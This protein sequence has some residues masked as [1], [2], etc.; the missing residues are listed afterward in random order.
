MAIGV[1]GGTFDPVHIGHLRVAEEIREA[2]GLDKVLFVPACYPPHKTERNTA[3]AQ[4]RLELLG[5]AVRTAGPLAVSDMEVRRGGMSY[6]IDTIQALEGEHPDLYFILGVDA[7]RDI[8]TW[9]RYPE[10]FFHTNFLVM[11]RESGMPAKILDLVP[12]DVRAL[13]KDK[14]DGVLEHGSGK[15]VYCYHVTRLDISSTRIRELVRAGKSIRYLVP[16][17]VEHYILDK[18]LYRN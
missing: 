5:L 18:G 7:F 4:T 12:P 10:L 1:F 13:M 8:H 16:E 2:F 11:T 15:R 9:R 3:D 17:A 14:G 6:S